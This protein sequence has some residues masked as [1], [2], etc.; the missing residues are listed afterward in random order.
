MRNSSSDVHL[1]KSFAL[2]GVLAF[3]SIMV[4]LLMSIASNTL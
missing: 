4:I 1:G 3:A 2:A